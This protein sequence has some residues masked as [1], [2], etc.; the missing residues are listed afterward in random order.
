MKNELLE[1]RP[2]DFDAIKNIAVLNFITTTVGDS[3]YILPLLQRLKKEAPNANIIITG[4]SLTKELIG[5]DKSINKYYTLPKIEKL[6]RSIGKIRKILILLITLARTYFLLRKEKPEL[7]IVLL[8]NFPIY[9]LVPTLAKV[10]IIAGYTYPGSKY[11]KYLTHKTPY[12][13]PDTTRE[14]NVHISEAYLKLLEELGIKTTKKDAI[15]KREVTKE[16]RTSAK[17][18]LSNLGIRKQ[19][20][21]FQP[22]AKYK[23]RQWPAELFAKLGSELI[24]KYNATIL[25]AGSLAEKE[26]CET[27]KKMIGNNCHNIAGKISLGTLAGIYKQ[28]DIAV[29]NDSGLM[30]LAASVGTQTVSIFGHPNPA[31][32]RPLGIKKA[33]I[34]KSPRWHKNAVFEEKKELQNKTSNYLLDITPEMILTEI[35]RYNKKNS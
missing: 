24:K 23:N 31:H 4:S 20:I 2:I 17:K 3:L 16:E 13:S 1:K 27:I 18:F 29:G 10:P 33:I 28:A 9:Q 14:V 26:L 8:P 7:C 34:I 35:S 5:N 25:L 32:S 15:L 21:I 12:R 11:S 30:H 22:G 6:G 19:L